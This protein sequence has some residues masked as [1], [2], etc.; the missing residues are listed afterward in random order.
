MIINF[1]PFAVDDVRPRRSDDTSNP[2][3][4]GVGESGKIIRFAGSQGE[5]SEFE[6]R[7]ARQSSNTMAPFQPKRPVESRSKSR[8]K[9][10]IY[11]PSRSQKVAN[12]N[13]AKIITAGFGA[14]PI[15]FFP[16]AV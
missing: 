11:K 13:G 14:I 7:A 3:A 16:E 6:F 12:E 9:L 8:F 4:D 10:T 2:A 5:D 15:D 1:S